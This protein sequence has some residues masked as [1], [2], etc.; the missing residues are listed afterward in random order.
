M[1]IPLKVT[2]DYSLLNS[3]IKVKDLISFCIQNNIDVC[4]ICDTNLY[5][6]IEFYKLAKDNN[7]KPIIG[8][9]IE[10]KKERIYL[11]AKDYIGY[12]NLLKINTTNSEREICIEDLKLYKNNVILVIP[13]ES[14]LLYDELN[15]FVDTFLSYKDK[16]ELKNNLAKTNSVVFIKDIKVLQ[17]RD[18]EY[19]KY[20]DIL[21]E[22][23]TKEYKNVSMQYELDDFD[24]LKINEF[25]K[26][27]NIEIPFGGRF[28]P[29]Y[30]EDINS[31]E[32]L[33]NLCKKGLN[34]RLN[35]NVTTKY[36]KRLEYELSVIKKMGFVDY[37]LIVYDYVLFAKK[38]NILVGPGRGSAA[39]S[40]VSYVIGITDIDPL[41]Y[42]LL[43][44]RFLN[45][46]RVTMPDIDIDFDNTKRDLVINYVKEKY[47]VL[48]VAGGMTYSTFKT[49]L[50]IREVGKILK[51]DER[52]L[53]KFIKVLNKDISL[54]DN[55]K[56]DVVKK[57]LNS[58][59]ILKKVYEISLKLEG[60]K[61]NIS[62]HAAGI[63]IGDR[64]L[65]E[66]IPMYKNGDVYL[67][68]ISME[69]LE[70]IGLLKMDFL[71][72]K[73][74]STIASIIEK[75]PNFKLQDINLEDKEVYE[76]FS[77]ANTG[78]I[79]QFET[80]AFKNMLTKYAPKNFSELV[81][82][83]ALVRPG[84]SVELE[85]Y[86]KRKKGLEKITYYHKD[87]EEILKETYGV[88]VYQEQVISILVKLGGF[89]YSEADNIRRAMSKKKIKII[90]DYE[91]T[92]ISNGIKLG[93]EKGVL[94]NVF[95]HILKFASYGFNKAH[96]VSYAIISYQ[97]AYLKVHYKTLFMFE[98]LNN[99]LGNNTLINNYLNEL[100]KSNIK[101]CKCDINKSLN[102]FNVI[103]N[104]LYLPWKMI[105][106][107]RSD[108]ILKILEE[109]SKC[110]FSDIFNFFE[111]TNGYVTKN[112][113][114]TL[115][116]A[117]LLNSLGYN[118]KTLINNLDSLINYGN[119]YKELGDYALKPNIEEFSNYDTETLRTNELNNYGFF[120]SNHPA[121]IYN[122]REVVKMKDISKY[123]FKNIISYV[124]V[125]NIKEIKTKKNEPMAFLSVSDETGISDLTIFP[126]NYNML[127]N[128][129]KN[130]M[131]K[132]WGNVT[133]RYDKYSVIVNK[134]SKE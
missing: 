116:N 57:Y 3:L 82:S 132:I 39:G 21:K 94:E 12:K 25:V 36:I 117:S 70:S 85:T 4:G 88:I 29:K 115:I 73:N 95:N 11:Y 44:E 26:L 2:S 119:L 77:S 51:V 43:F 103:N 75:I 59:E 123:A 112:E 8:L 122:E 121:S 128:I 52:L 90:K 5:S 20:L 118:E 54:K 65:D 48:N 17:D 114:T 108:L 58:Y 53:N 133:K 68:G 9:E 61:K 104:T 55:L 10:Y 96:S 62:T 100:K 79:F 72:L 111:R 45:V 99:S 30:K 14:M 71:A 19:L 28:I 60:L 40:L 22:V 74:L 6:S 126:N 35:N 13:S 7:I 93:Y 87:L 16:I 120:I 109:R 37:F 76:L 63:V 84:P 80:S 125:E 86:I 31:Y 41:K 92:F 102:K 38:N 131:I 49:R 97:M 98:L 134:I 27:I 78:G 50:V 24:K 34:K 42:D 69:L 1:N 83:I 33:E 106:N 127:Q 105:K 47:G 56:L 129:R 91:N 113:Y 32:F 15:F 23:D 110:E 46:N 89:T 107:L 124:M 18:T 130:D 101:I 64:N 81:A 67:T 66:I